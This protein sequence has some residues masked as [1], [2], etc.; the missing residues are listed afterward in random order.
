MNNFVDAVLQ[1]KEVANS[2]WEKKNWKHKYQK[3][4]FSYI[5]RSSSQIE[6]ESGENFSEW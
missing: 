6:V 4:N 3:C 2:N 1:L 5:S